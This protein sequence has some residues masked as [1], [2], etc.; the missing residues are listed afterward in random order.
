[1]ASKL[2]SL[3]KSEDIL[4]VPGAYD[5]I[6]GRAVLNKGFKVMY[7]TGA[8]TVGSKLGTPDLGIAGLTDMHQ[9]AAML[10]GLNPE[11]P[12]IADADTGYGG[13]L[14]CAR[15]LRLYHQ[16]GIAGLHVEDQALG[17]KRCGHLEGKQIIDLEAYLIRIKAM[18]EERRRLGSELVIIARS[19]A[20]QS[21]GVDEAI[22]RCKAA[23]D[24]GADMAFVEGITTEVE[25]KK[26]VKEIAPA[27]ALVNLVANGVTPHWTVENARQ[28]GFKLALFPLVTVVPAS[29]AIEKSLDSLIEIGSDAPASKGNSPEDFFNKLGLK[30]LSQFDGQVGGELNL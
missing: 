7:M 25:A 21:Y 24:V 17:N 28:L 27:P 11:V 12:V 5:G 6:S 1:M 16:A 19:D 15:T 20:L 26:V 18:V 4:V 14:S 3:L 9:N 30:E 8:G 2:R 10:S 23:I 29:L 13:P 22:S